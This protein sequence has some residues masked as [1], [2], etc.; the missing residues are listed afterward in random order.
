MQIATY[1]NISASYNSGNV[2]DKIAIDIAEIVFRNT[3]NHP[4]SFYNMAY[5]KLQFELIKDNK[6]YQLSFVGY[7]WVADT[8]LQYTRHIYKALQKKYSVSIVFIDSE[9][10]ITLEYSNK[11]YWKTLLKNNF[12]IYLILPPLIILLFS[13]SNYLTSLLSKL[14]TNRNVLDSILENAL[15]PLI[16]YPISVLAFK[17][18][19]MITITKIATWLVIL[20]TTFGF[21][22]YSGNGLIGALIL[23]VLFILRSIQR[24]IS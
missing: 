3:S 15:Y 13:L 7:R 23:L 20:F 19:P 18:Q 17:I 12:I 14:I 8:Y 22:L 2:E 9:R 11:N 10:N 4:D 16:C 21:Y 1:G 24:S 6:G 5:P